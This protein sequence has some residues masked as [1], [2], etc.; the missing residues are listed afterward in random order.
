MLAAIIRTLLRADIPKNM[1][2][3]AFAHMVPSARAATFYNVILQ[4]PE[5]GGVGPAG[6]GV[7]NTSPN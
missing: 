2:R 1:V 4:V 7:V 6:G 5:R 3:A